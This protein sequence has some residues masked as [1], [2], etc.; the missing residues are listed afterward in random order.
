[1]K[2]EIQKERENIKLKTLNNVK[3]DDLK[4]QILENG[5]ICEKEDMKNVLEPGNV[6]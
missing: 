5:K 6:D 1:M 4:G 2:K 3:Q